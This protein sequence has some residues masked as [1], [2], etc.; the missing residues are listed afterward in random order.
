MYSSP[1][2]PNIIYRWHEHQSLYVGLTASQ[3]DALPAGLYACFNEPIPLTRSNNLPRNTRGYLTCWVYLNSVDK[4]YQWTS[5][6][7][8]IFYAWI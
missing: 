5:N 6:D 3:F 1:D 4:R 8:V 2:G 7:N